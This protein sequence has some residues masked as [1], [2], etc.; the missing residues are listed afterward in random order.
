MTVA[1]SVW[2]FGDLPMGR[3]CGPSYMLESWQRELTAQGLAP[4]TFTP[5]TGLRGRRREATAVTFRALRHVGYSGDYHARFSTL[6]ELLRARKNRPNVILVATLGRVGLLG[7]IL[8]AF[9]SIPLVLVVSTDTTG[10]AD[11]YNTPRAIS[12]G[13]IKPAVLMLVSRRCRAAFF[14][15]SEHLRRGL[16]NLSRRA[17]AHCAAAL[18]AEAREVVLL[19]PKCLPM[20]GE[21]PEG[22]R[23]TVFP[24]GIDRLPAAPLPAELVWRPGALRVLYVGR[25]APEKGL[26]ILLQA[27]RIA[28]DSGVDAHLTLVGEGP[29]RERLLAEGARLG[30]GDRLTVIGPFPRNELGGIYAS[31]DVFAFPSVVDTQAFVLNEAAH[32]G[33]ALLVSDTA[34][35]V[36]RDGESALV[37]PPEPAHYAAGLA[38]LCDRR[39]RDRLGTAAR[40][41]A[42]EVGETAQSARLAQVLRRAAGTGPTAVTFALTDTGSHAVVHPGPEV[43]LA[44][45][46]Y[47]DGLLA[48][49][50]D[51]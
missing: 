19:S 24:A 28:V 29:L 27:L 18:H 9:Y 1:V 51:F 12:S 30:I 16:A 47:E 13:G 46:P 42:E 6:A 41:R 44:D 45:G 33:L 43:A 4:R 49:A 17:A 26:P 36:V 35:Y 15:R 5:A 31:A 32:E 50:A 2:I 7:V 25:F 11:Y 10:A 8:A 20:Y 39:L 3:A 23:V 37:V 40:H 48:D 22:T 38:R 21:A 14:R 34:N